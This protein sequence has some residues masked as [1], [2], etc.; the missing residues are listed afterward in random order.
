MYCQPGLYAAQQSVYILKFPHTDVFLYVS[1]N[2]LFE[3]RGE[4]TRV[5]WLLIVHAALTIV[6][7]IVL[8]TKKRTLLQKKR[9]E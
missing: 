3:E 5:F 7:N 1:I 4:T 9:G 6:W 2:I 8:C